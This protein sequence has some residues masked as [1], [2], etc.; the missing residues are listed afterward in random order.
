MEVILTED[1]VGVGDIGDV[2]KVRPG[3]ARNYLIPRG[4]AVEAETSNAKMMEHRMRQITA[5]KRRLKG[6]AEELAQRVRD[7]VVTVELRI[8]ASGKVFGAVTAREIAEKLSAAI[9]YPLDRKRIVI[10]EPIKR[11][12]THFVKVKLHQEV[13]AQLKLTVAEIRASEEEDAQAVAEV[14]ERLEEK[15]A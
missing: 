11:V 9:D 4:F 5:K 14:K 1:V 3:F 2:V 15:T 12:G 8:G 13:E 7:A 6:A 10:P